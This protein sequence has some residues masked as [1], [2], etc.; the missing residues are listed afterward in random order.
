MPNK[1]SHTAHSEVGSLELT[2]QLIRERAYAYYE[3]R[4]REEGHELEDWLRAEAEIIGKK[5]SDSETAH[6]P[7]LA[8]AAAA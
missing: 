4:G 5:P 7:V 8:S 1:K 6:E 2:E 3:Q